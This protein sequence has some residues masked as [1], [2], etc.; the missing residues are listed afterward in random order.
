M[1]SMAVT[2]ESPTL[3]EWLEPPQMDTGSPCPAIHSDEHRLLCAY[4]VGDRVMPH[5]TVAVLRFEG[6][7]QF[8]LGYPN[9]EALQGHPL[10]K[11][12][13]EP[14]AAYLVENSPLIAEIENQNRVHPAFRP[15][16]YSKFRHWIITFHDETLEVV[17]QRAAVVGTLQLPPG[18]AVCDQGPG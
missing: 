3:H 9:D 18:R 12:K 8:R 15:G 17:A 2:P 16:M 14:Y 4:Y 1:S 13:L 6:V 5:G 10:A 7:L 11:F